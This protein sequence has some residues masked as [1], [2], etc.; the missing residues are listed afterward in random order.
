MIVMRI[1]VSRGQETHNNE[2]VV[3]SWWTIAPLSK[4]SPPP[5]GVMLGQVKGRDSTRGCLR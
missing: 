5:L 4:Q 2:S 1:V 3:G